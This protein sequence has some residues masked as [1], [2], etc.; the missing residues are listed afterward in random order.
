[1]QTYLPNAQILSTEQGVTDQNGKRNVYSANQLSVLLKPFHRWLREH[2]DE[3]RQ[4]AAVLFLLLFGR[5]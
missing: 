2:P 3:S 5:S 4:A 1:M